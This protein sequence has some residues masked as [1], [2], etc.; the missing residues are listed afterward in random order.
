MRKEK[1]TE[2]DIKHHF[3]WVTKYRYEIMEK[4]M[5]IRLW[6]VNRKSD[7]IYKGIETILNRG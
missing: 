6:I 1:T 5:G 4:Q 2:Y 7:N 3:V